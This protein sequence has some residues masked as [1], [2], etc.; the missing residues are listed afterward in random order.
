M[1][2]V[3]GTCAGRVLVPPPHG[4]DRIYF[5]I[6]QNPT[7]FTQTISSL[8][9]PKR[10]YKLTDALIRCL[11][12]VQPYHP[13]YEPL[14]F[15]RELANADKHRLPLVVIGDIETMTTDVIT[16]SRNSK[17]PP[18][19]TD[20]PA[21]YEPKVNTQATVCVTWQDTFMP[22]EP[23]ERTLEDFVKIVADIVPRFDPFV[24]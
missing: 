18:I 13:G 21:Y 6:C 12:L 7:S 5:P 22:P 2:E 8:N 10:N 23:V 14:S 3:V 24:L 15:F 4:D 11:E 1:W 20:D 17:F 16:I 19:L 9:S